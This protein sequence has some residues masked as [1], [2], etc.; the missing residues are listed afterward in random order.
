MINKHEKKSVY[1][2]TGMGGYLTTGLGQGLLDQGFQVEGRE[3]VGDFKKLR[4]QQQLDLIVDDLTNY[5]WHKDSCVIANS[6]GAY[7][8]LNAQ[9]QIQP[10]VGKVILLS[11]ILGDFSNDETLTT[12]VPPF[13]GRILD[14]AKEN[15]FP[16]PLNCEIHVGELDWQSNPN[17]VIR[18]AN[19]LGVKAFIVPKAGHMLPRDYVK[20][21]LDK[22]K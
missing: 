6:F 13:A 5:F 11:P 18:F 4:F 21:L 15:K 12:F 9:A 16:V 2:I 7:L 20:K 17:N 8:F 14:L 19:M 10:Y 22:F 1:Y 3:L